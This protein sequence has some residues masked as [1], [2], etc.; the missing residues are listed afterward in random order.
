LFVFL[1]ES[2][3]VSRK[4]FAKQGQFP[5]VAAVMLMNDFMCSA[6]IIA[7]DAVLTAAICLG[8]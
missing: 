7:D 1:A 4:S 5:E 3:A 8:M 6:S 2:E